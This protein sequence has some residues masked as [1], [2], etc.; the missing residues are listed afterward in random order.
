[1]R[2][3]PKTECHKLSVLTPDRQTLEKQM[4]N[5]LQKAIEHAHVDDFE[6]LGNFMD[7]LV[8]KFCE[9]EAEVK[10]QQEWDKKM[11]HRLTYFGCSDIALDVNARKAVVGN[12]R[13]N[14]TIKELDLLTCFLENAGTVLS[15]D[16]LLEHCGIKSVYGGKRGV[17]TLINRLRSKLGESAYS[18]KTLRGVGYQFEPANNGH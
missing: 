14:L 5:N 12:K 9:T 8:S 3:N 11:E 2:T 13:I 4:H 17:D 1:M 15:R 10:K 6:N 18:I 16:T 7:L